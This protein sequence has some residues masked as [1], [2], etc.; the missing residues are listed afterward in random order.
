MDRGYTDRPTTIEFLVN[1][2]PT[3]R[4]A[5]ASPPAQVFNSPQPV[6]PAGGDTFAGEVILLV[7]RLARTMTAA[8]SAV[9]LSG[10]AACAGTERIA[11]ECTGK[12]S[13]TASGSSA[14]AEAIN[15]FAAVYAGLCRGR[16]VDYTSAGSAVGRADFIAGRTDF[17]GSDTPLGATAGEQQMARSRCGGHPAWNLPLVF[18]AIAIIYN[19]SGA[20]SLALDAATAAK[21]FNGTINSWDAPEIAA[22][23]PG[24][25]LP[26]S[27]IVVIARTDESGTTDNFQRYL[28]A[29]AGAAWGTGAGE[30]FRG[31]A[32]KKAKGN[33]GM[34][35]TLRSVPGSI[36]YVA[37]PFAKRN[38][39]T[40]ARLV[41]SAGSEPVALSVDSVS[42]SIAGIRIQSPGN[43]VLLDTSA[44]YEP[45][46]PGAYPIVMTSYEIVCSVYPDSETASAVRGF[47]TAALEAG[48]IGL[49]DEGYVPVPDSV[50]TRL[51]AAIA[52]IA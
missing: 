30:T 23:N 15:H 24:L 36:T 11:A 34:W 28:Q 27:P 50:R 22:L 25:R 46:Q 5:R 14:Q 12:K 52:A 18:G 49:T 31:V 44:L 38:D 19:V 3:R 4:G 43:D 2:A 32:G 26:G 21:I 41:T 7:N 10:S 9:A 45:T 35:A 51:S 16:G 13:L 39:L 42:R 8:V 20:G 33:E 37:W 6:V 47:L 29:A 40:S 48:Q 17:G 1:V